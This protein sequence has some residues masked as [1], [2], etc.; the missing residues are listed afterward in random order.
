MR[1]LYV[2]GLYTDGTSHFGC[3]ILFTFHEVRK[4]KCTFAVSFTTTFS[5]L[6][7]VWGMKSYI[8]GLVGGGIKCIYKSDLLDHR[9][10]FLIRVGLS[11][12]LL[13]YGTP[14]ST[15]K[16]TQN[17][18]TSSHKRFYWQSHDGCYRHGKTKGSPTHK[19]WLSIPQRP[20]DILT[21]RPLDLLTSR[22]LEPWTCWPLEQR[23]AFVIR[24][25]LDDG[26]LQKA[27]FFATIH[28]QT[29]PQ[30]KPQEG[31]NHS[32]KLSKNITSG[33]SDLTAT[34][35]LQSYTME[36]G[37]LHGSFLLI[38]VECCH[39]KPSTNKQNVNV[40]VH[41]VIIVSRGKKVN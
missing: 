33:H 22:P 2:Y 19:H 8:T 13:R 17:L 14:V 4:L 27:V 12:L 18:Q 30:I 9:L 21:C 28:I 20:L 39:N 3:L 26:P 38:Y 7:N 34:F 10:T 25:C 11:L 32:P 15:K 40:V 5:K 41:N 1:T 36:E 16:T 37:N 35:L 6:E 31:V 24:H 23:I 29:R